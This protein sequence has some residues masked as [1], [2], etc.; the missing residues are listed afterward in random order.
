MKEIKVSGQCEQQ[1]NG[2][3][4]LNKNLKKGLQNT[5]RSRAKYEK[6][7]EE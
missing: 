4:E 1:N 6:Q 3:K 7:G 5:F 2:R